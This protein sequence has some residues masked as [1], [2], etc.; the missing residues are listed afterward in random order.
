LEPTALFDDLA[1]GFE[2]VAAG[3]IMGNGVGPG[4]LITEPFRPD[5]VKSVPGRDT[6]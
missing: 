1:A 5:G 3:A 6:R 2:A 4:D